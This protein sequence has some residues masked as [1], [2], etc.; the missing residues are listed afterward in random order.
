MAF[1]EVLAKI[2]K[3]INK[4]DCCGSSVI[5]LLYEKVQRISTDPE[6]QTQ[7]LTEFFTQLRAQKTFVNTQQDL[8]EALEQFLST[9]LRTAEV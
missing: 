9:T 6:V 4:G 1:M 8:F 2:I 3:T 7:T 5:D